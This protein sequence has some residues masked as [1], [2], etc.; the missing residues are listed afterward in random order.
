MANAP[1]AGTP[2]ELKHAIH[3]DIKKY[4]KSYSTSTKDIRNARAHDQEAC[5]VCLKLG[6]PG[7]LRRCAKCKHASYCS[8]ECQR[9]DWPIHKKACSN[10]DSGIDMAKITQ[11]LSA[12]TFLSMQLQA[13]FVMA[14]DLLRQPRLDKPFVARVDIGIEPTDIM[15]F[16]NIYWGGPRKN[17]KACALYNVF[18]II[19]YEPTMDLVRRTPKF[20][21]ISAVTGQVTEEPFDIPGCLEFMNKHIRA[22]S[23]NKLSLRTEMTPSDIQTIR[24][25]ASDN[26]QTARSPN[27]T[28]FALPPQFA[29]SLL[30]EKMSRETIYKIRV[31]WS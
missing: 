5:A 29:C 3:P 7:E 20:K 24:D 21:K 13:C 8:K 22:D 28:E 18:P 23:K 1:S 17:L 2:I 27:W 16:F 10:V 6:R 31:E 12:S 25:A 26:I 19:I 11:I 30:K 9:R 4:H 15:D 14:F